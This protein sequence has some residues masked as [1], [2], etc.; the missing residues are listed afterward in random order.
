[1]INKCVRWAAV[2]AAVVVGPAM[3]PA[4]QKQPVPAKVTDGVELLR[5]V[6]YGTGGSRPLKMHILRPRVAPKD[7]MP[8]LVWIHGGGWSGGNKESGIG[9]LSPYANR[10]YFCAPP[11]NIG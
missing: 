5:D 8:V 6:D 11:S 10:G 1:M 7:A 2:L 4:Q 9:L 3:A